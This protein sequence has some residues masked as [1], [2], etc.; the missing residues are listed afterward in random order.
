MSIDI[1][2]PLPLAAPIDDA[3]AGL[4]D[5]TSTA[6]RAPGYAG[7]PLPSYTPL[8]LNDGGG[9]FG[10]VRSQIAGTPG[11]SAVFG[12]RVFPG[13][14]DPQTPF[15]YVVL[16]FV[17][18][19]FDDYMGAAYSTHPIPLDTWKEVVQVSVYADDLAA[20]MQLA[21]M[22][23]AVVSRHTLVVDYMPVFMYPETKQTVLEERK[24]PR[25]G[26]VWHRDLRYSFW[27]FEWIFEDTRDFNPQDIPFNT[28][29]GNDFAW[30][31]PWDF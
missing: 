31:P 24:S 14:A 7:T 9:I 11:Y 17:S 29:T 25:G 10:A 26:D 15:P 8:Y 2:S 4:P 12:D 20:C 6:R 27:S 18:C 30:G 22:V 5:F 1:L 19:V 16:S 3:V 23:H 28:Q 13:R 21:H